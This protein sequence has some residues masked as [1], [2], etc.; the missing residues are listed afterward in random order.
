MIEQVYSKHTYAHAHTLLFSSLITLY[1]TLFFERHNKKRFT[2][3]TNWILAN[4]NDDRVT[5]NGN[6]KIVSYKQQAQTS[7][8]RGLNELTCARY[9]I[10]DFSIIRSMIIEL[11]ILYLASFARLT[12]HERDLI[13]N[14][15]FQL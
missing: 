10:I 11:L 8:H 3:V 15:F 5:R 4:K 9:N 7:T 12:S 2:G 6:V 13:T 1:Y 14:D